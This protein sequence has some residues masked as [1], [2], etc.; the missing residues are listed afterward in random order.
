MTTHLHP[1]TKRMRR[2]IISM[3]ADGK[4]SHVGCALSCV[5]ILAALYFKLM[6][7]TPGNWQTPEA[8]RFILSKG[9]GV[10]AWYAVLAEAGFFPVE[11]LHTY[12][13]DGSYLG[14]H[15]SHAM[16]RGIGYSTGSLGHGLAVAVGQALARK[17]D[18]RPGNIFVLLSDGE[19]NEGSVWEAAMCAAQHALDNL[20]AVIDDNGMQAM[21]PSRGI[22][23]LD[24]LKEKWAAFGWEAVECDGHDVEALVA[25]CT[26]LMSTKGKPKVLIARTVL[27]KG[28]S[29][30]ENRILWHY[31]IPSADDV[32]RAFEELKR[33]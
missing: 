6:N 33:A 17:M 23:A 19:C 13:A 28:V 15:P 26:K 21:G 32:R 24:P 5:E 2:H 14:E 3:A 9:H 8:D 7:V 20:V 29:F 30:M 27:A 1:K 4:T 22:S 31:Q 16:G 10:M 18:K 11:E 25:H 12:A